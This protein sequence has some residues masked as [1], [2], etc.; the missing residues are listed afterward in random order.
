MR[1]QYREIYLIGFVLLFVWGNVGCTTIPS[2]KVA[3]IN[4][5]D[6]FLYVV[7]KNGIVKSLSVKNGSYELVNT[8][9]FPDMKYGGSFV[10]PSVRGVVK[11]TRHLT[12]EAFQS[13]IFPAEIN[14]YIVKNRELVKLGGLPYSTFLTAADTRYLY[15]L[16]IQLKIVDGVQKTVVSK[17]I[18]YEKDLKTKVNS[19]FNDKQLI[20]IDLWDDKDSYW[21]TTTVDDSAFAISAISGRLEFSGSERIILLAVNKQNGEFQQFE[22]SGGA[23]YITNEIDGIWFFGNQAD[24]TKI[25]Q[26]D[27]DK[28]T[29][30]KDWLPIKF[31]PF[32][33]DKFSKTSDYLW[34]T[35]LPCPDSMKIYRINKNDLSFVTIPVPEDVRIESFS[36]IYSDDDTLWIGATK[37]R[38]LPPFMNE[39]PYVIKIRKDNLDVQLV[40]I[41]PSIGEA[42]ETI[43]KSFKNW[44]LVPFAGKT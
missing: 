8:M 4:K 40:L 14:I 24:G 39:V 18:R 35:S 32:P 6:D 19:H 1:A 28:K 38:D 10:D 16:E 31:R 43:W 2:T 13:N 33:H 36:A 15:G 3:L 12:I 34:G 29:Y 22:V 25:V 26:F 21:Y 9:E 11:D 30:R 17:A 23:K 27:K 7:M 37:H 41:K 42:F 5:S 20:I 44:L